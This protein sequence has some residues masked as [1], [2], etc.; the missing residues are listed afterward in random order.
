MSTQWSGWPW[1][2]DDRGE[3]GGVDVAAAGWRTC[4]CRSPSRCVDVAAAHEVAAARA[5]RG[6]AVASPSTE[7]YGQLHV[8]RLHALDLGAEEPR[9]ELAERVDVAAGDERCTPRPRRRRRAELAARRASAAHLERGLVG[10]RHEHDVAAHDVADR[11][12]QQRVVRAAEHERVDVGVA[13]PAR[14][15]A[16][17]ARAPGRSRRRPPRRTR[18]SPGTRRTSARSP[19]PSVGRGPLVRAR[20]DGADGADH[21]DPA[22]AGRRHARPARPARSRRRPARR[23]RS[24][25]ASSAAADAAVA[26]DDDHLHVVLDEQVGDLERVL[27]H[28]VGRLGAVR[29]PAGVAEVDEVARRAAGRSAPAAP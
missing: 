15:A 8:P 21:A 6:R 14:A 28:L 22:G 18:R 1:R 16:R 26:R 25:S 27:Q 23:A 10:A 5:A 12:G 11:A 3:V 20:R 17:R 13:A 9:A 4:R 29:E 19:A 24:R 2:D 7:H